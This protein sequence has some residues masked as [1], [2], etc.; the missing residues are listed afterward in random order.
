MKGGY[1]RAFPSNNTMGGMPILSKD[2]WQVAIEMKEKIENPHF[3]YP[4]FLTPVCITTFVTAVECYF[5]ETI[6][7]LY[8][9]SKASGKKGDEKRKN[10]IKDLQIGKEKL[11]EVFY[12]FSGK[13]INKQSG[14]YNDMLCA[15]E[16]RHCLIHFMPNM[17]AKINDWPRRLQEAV[18]R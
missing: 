8:F 12:Y 5:N 1:F 9:V 7:I 6:E 3:K 14:Y 16:V 4:H 11:K 2:Y 17:E 10:Y 13:E 15:I 18:T